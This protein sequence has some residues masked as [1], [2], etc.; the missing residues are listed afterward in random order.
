MEKTPKER[1]K[2]FSSALAEFASGDGEFGRS[3][4]FVTYNQ[5]LY[6][7]KEEE[8]SREEIL[9][10]VFSALLDRLDRTSGA[11]AEVLYLYTFRDFLE[12]YGEEPAVQAVIRKYLEEKT[13][14]K[15]SLQTALRLRRKN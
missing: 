11:V 3:E 7:L 13:L 15:P 8:A 12:T 4:L 2:C 14:C 9:A 10:F 1:Q 5:L 6:S